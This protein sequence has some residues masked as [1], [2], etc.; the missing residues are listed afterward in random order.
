MIKFP[1]TII[2]KH[3]LK[4]SAHPLFGAWSLLLVHVQF[5]PSQGPTC[6]RMPI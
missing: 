5:T 3:I 4:K 2:S 1:N 6:L